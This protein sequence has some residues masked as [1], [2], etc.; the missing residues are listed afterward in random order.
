MT[1]HLPRGH[2]L[3]RYR[4]LK[5]QLRLAIKTFPLR[6][7]QIIFRLSHKGFR[8]ALAT[9]R[10]PRELPAPLGIRRVPT[11]D[12]LPRPLNLTYSASPVVSIIVSLFENSGNVFAC[13]DSIV[14]YSDGIPL[15]IIVICNSFDISVIT[16]LACTPN[17]ILLKKSDDLGGNSRFKQAIS[18]AR[19]SN[20][21]FIH[22]DIMVTEGW[23]GALLEVF[24]HHSHIGA[25][26]PKFLSPAGKLK[27][28]YQSPSMTGSNT[29]PCREEDANHP[30]FNYVKPT[31]NC[32]DACV[33][34]PKH[35][36]TQ[37]G[38]NEK[39]FS[40]ISTAI[41]HLCLTM[42][43]QGFQLLYQPKAEVFHYCTRNGDGTVTDKL[44]PPQNAAQLQCKWSN[45][46]SSPLLSD[47][48]CPW[49]WF[50]SQKPHILW[51]EAC[52]ITPDQD[53]GSLRTLRLLQ[54]LIKM[55]CRVSFI[56]DNPT[57]EWRYVSSL[58]QAGIEVLYPPHEPSVLDHLV[59]HG[60]R[61]EMVVL[62]R[63]YIA[64][65]YLGLIKS[66]APRAKVIFDT[67]DLHY[68]RLRRQAEFD[69][70][71]QIARL[72]KLA[73]RQEMHLIRAC[74]LTLVVSEVEQAILAKE[75]PQVPIMVLSNV[76]DSI[77]RIPPFSTRQDILFVGGFQHPPNLD[78]ITWYAQDIWPK[79]R[80]ELPHV[81]TFVIGS[82]MPVQFRQM[83]QAAGLDMLG[84]VPDLEPYLASCRLSI[85]PLRFGAGVKG[86]VNQSMSHGLP[87]VATSLSIEGM[88][89][90]PEKNMLVADDAESFATCIVRLYQDKA[91]WD[92]ISQEGLVNVTQKFSSEVAKDALVKILQRLGLRS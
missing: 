49:K 75:A 81:R 61:Y 7:E 48:S 47:V 55:R 60:S 6:I 22:E 21:L 40:S 58:Q 39:H 28:I 77:S 82:K 71:P 3:Q 42:R 20:I 83:G 72:A 37:F 65:K 18:V 50:E 87:V 41:W 44:P 69:G 16:P 73:Y 5:G 4:L 38:G 35:L 86:K 76:H 31:V 52:L 13:I 63:H 33:L 70:N 56:S 88:G 62:S 32:S 79:V 17:L 23:L 89:V 80:N 25:V 27:I 11:L 36:L 57:F 64:S 74:D 85:S 46:F 8:E 12:T 30:E 84:Y 45:S 10:A 53:S 14:K 15:E 34:F 19:A 2:F 68:L 24:N 92:R 67:V 1:I 29:P 51:I 91:L 66:L 9:L 26:I 54:I 59:L 90:E 43:S 78:A